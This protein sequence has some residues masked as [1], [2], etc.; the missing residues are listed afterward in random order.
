MSPRNALLALAAAAALAGCG[1]PG[2]S[3]VG[4]GDTRRTAASNSTPTKPSRARAVEVQIELGR[5]YMDRGQYETAHEALQKA[6]SMD[7]DSVDANT[8]MAVLYE[9]INR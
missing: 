6:L 9:R 5:Q 3:D 8:L 1:G 7:A 2:V 4:R